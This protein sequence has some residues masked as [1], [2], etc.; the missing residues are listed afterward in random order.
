M[1][2]ISDGTNYYSVNAGESDGAYET[3]MAACANAQQF[4][5]GNSDA[6]YNPSN[7]FALGGSCS[8]AGS[9][10]A[11]SSNMGYV[12]DGNGNVWVDANF[13]IGGNG[14]D[15]N[16]PQSACSQCK[17]RQ[18]KGLSP[19]TPSVPQYIEIGDCNST[20]S[21]YYDVKSDGNN[22]FYTLLS[23]DTGNANPSLACQMAKNTSPNLQNFTFDKTKGKSCKSLGSAQ[24][25]YNYASQGSMPTQAKINAEIASAIE[26]FTIFSSDDKN[27]KVKLIILGLILLAILVLVYILFSKEEKKVDFYFC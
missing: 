27:K 9:S 11:P 20:G 4:L 23:E 2:Y 26:P 7:G 10:F 3:P 13:N 14:W 6:S 17:D 22:W 1:A 19:L 15:S 8:S 18:Q 12:C 25:V 16:S 24:P 21:F 5:A